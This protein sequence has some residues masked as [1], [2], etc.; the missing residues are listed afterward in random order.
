MTRGAAALAGLALLLSAAA[1]APPRPSPDEWASTAHDP[2]EQR[3]SPLAQLTPA[4]VGELGL[5][6]YADIDT[7]RGQ[8]A[9]PVMTGGVLYVTT[10]WSMVKAFDART[11][12]PLWS[13]DPKVERT[14]GA[15]AC[16]DV[17]NRG[18]AVADGRVFLGALD[19]RLIAL[20]ARTGREL[21][22]V[23][24]TDTS[25]PYTVTAA[26]RVI[27]GKVIVGN[28]G[29][30]YRTR[31]YLSA[32]D[33][34]TG[35]FAWRWYVV[36]GDP[37]KP[38]EQPELK[39]AAKT[40]TGEW[41]RIG[42]G[43]NPW[44]GMAYD[45]ELN[46]LFVGTGNGNPWNPAVRSPGG[47]DNLFLASVVALDPD[48][49]RYKCHLQETPEDAWDYTST[50]PLMVAELP[51]PG[52]RRKVVMH[53]PKNGLFFVLDARTCRPVAV[54]KFGPI[55]WASG[56]DMKSGRPVENAE[57][58][59][60]RTGRPA[61]VTPAALGMHN[62]HPM[63]FSPRTGLVYLPVQVANAAYAGVKDFK[64]NLSGWN[65][66]TD[67]ALGQELYKQPGAPKPGPQESY[68]LA[69]DPVAMKEVWRA[70]NAEYGSSG[71][72]ATAGDLVFSG[73]HAGRFSAY[74]ARSGRRVWSAS[75][76][77]KVVAAPAAYALD[78]EE[79][80]AVLVGARGLPPGQARTSGVSA[81]N[82][83]LLVF[84]R[85]GRARLPTA[86]VRTAAAAA[87]EF[88]P[89]LLTASNET[90]AAG[91]QGYGRACGLCHGRGATAGEGAIAPDLRLSALI[92]SPE[93]FGRVVLEGERAQRGMPGFKATLSHEDAEAI[94][95]YL[96]KRANDAKAARTAGT[97][98]P[99]A[100]AGA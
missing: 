8:E 96:I 82:S 94:R 44:D 3:Y 68:I 91:E 43:G 13:Y 30:E 83:R 62:W 93:Q 65:T 15:D 39:A 45:A 60:H 9:T 36:P 32:Y 21:W 77:A 53:A 61:I 16:C 88:D 7:E 72:L 86:P 14:K 58:R 70:P 52:G 80:V 76:G 48:T 18:V 78:G 10:A 59:Y 20:D 66:G 54:E 56:W 98:A 27:H 84:A 87:G 4:N 71:L 34:R 35:R 90:V 85:G 38:F 17:V 57:A 75:A 25:L 69:W 67:F 41:W 23:Q 95:A 24:T 46:T 63:A 81:N 37:S 29:A 22:S 5:K 33:A 40:W 92:A 51:Y 31:G 1:P 42:G 100:R 12:A 6:W 73:D 26:P 99:G 50:Q 11:G 47:G 74:E 97:A 19:G 89:P 79:Q 28:G 2:W 49:G 64:L 55:T